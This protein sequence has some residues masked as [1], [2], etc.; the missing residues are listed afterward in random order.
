MCGITGFLDTSRTK[1][2]EQLTLTARRMS[3]SLSHRGPEDEG[4]WVDPNVGIALG[5]RRLSIIDL[6]PM[7]HQPM[8]SASGRYVITFN[9]EIY[10]F[11]ALRQELEQLG[12][13][14]RGHSDTEIMLAAIARWGVEAALKKFNGM[15]AF[16]L[17]DREEQILY[18]SRDR[19]GEKPLYY[20]WAGKTL[21]FGS[22]L[23]SLQQHPDFRGDIDRGAIAVFLRH[24]YIPAPHSIYKGI[25]KLPAGTVLAIR[26]FGSDASPKP[27]WSAKV[28]AEDGIT[29]PFRGSE[30]EAVSQLDALLHDAVTMRMEADVPLGAFLSGGIDSSLIVAIMQAN[31]KRP[32]KTFTIGFDNRE[33]NEAEAAKLVAQ[34]LGTEHT[35]LYVTPEEAMAVIPRLPTLYDEPFADSSQIPTFLVSQLARRNVTVSLSGDGGDE[36]FGGYTTYQWGRSVHQNIGWMPG[37]LKA[38][39]AKT[40]K[41]LSKLDWNALLDGRQSVVPESLRSKDINKV[42]SK[43]TGILKVNEREALYW[44]LL[45]YWMEPSSVV[46]GANEPLTQLTDSTKWAHIDDIMHV[47]MYLDTIMYLPDDILVKVDRASMGVSLESRVP[48]LDHRV[49]E[50]AWKLPIEMKVKGTLGKVPLRNLLYRYVPQQLVDRPK[51]GFGVPIHEWLRGPMRSWAEDLLDESRLKSEGFFAAKPIHQKWN[52]HVSGRRNWQAQLWAVLMFQAWLEQ[53]KV[54]ADLEPSFDRSAVQ[55]PSTSGA[56]A[57]PSAT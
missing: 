40:I 46:L 7:G 51:K 1:S 35:E 22:E 56:S 34:H 24:N 16:G 3:T 19:A 45:S 14:F 20:G 13:T 42:L 21:L 23:K 10:N 26:G 9:G 31:S 6:S 12:E 8:H 29:N 2:T 38:G 54:H 50:F 25:Y 52:E 11:K 48:L 43:L 30:E 27:Y 49:I 47:M 55:I 28:A 18:L 41:P 57:H 33:Y 32:V 5:H 44:I 36:L 37:P 53:Q 15:F 4:V 17:W 39:L